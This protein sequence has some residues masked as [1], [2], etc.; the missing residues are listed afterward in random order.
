MPKVTAI[1]R[2]PLGP[3]LTGRHPARIAREGFE[4]AIRDAATR[5]EL[6]A[7]GAKI[8]QAWS[9]GTVNGPVRDRLCDAAFSRWKMVRASRNL[10]PKDP[11]GYHQPAVDGR[12]VFPFLSLC[13]GRVPRRRRR[14][15]RKGPHLKGTP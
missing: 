12:T 2:R 3:D 14:G 1:L 6:D 7:I 9:E 13:L 11:R 5:S 4:D 15:H 8:G 10:T